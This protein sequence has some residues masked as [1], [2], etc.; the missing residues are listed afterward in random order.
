MS[1]RKSLVLGLAVSSFALAAS[2][3]TPAGERGRYRISRSR[4]TVI[5]SERF[6]GQ[7]EDYRPPAFPFTSAYNYPG[8]Y[9]NNTFWERVQTQRQYPVQY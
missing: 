9:N 7:T 8:H 4:G 6:I 5:Y 2:A 3:Q 1:L